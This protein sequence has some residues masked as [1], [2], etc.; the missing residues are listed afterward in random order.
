MDGYIICLLCL[1]LHWF[2]DT[3]PFV[4]TCVMQYGLLYGCSYLLA[5]LFLSMT[6]SS[7]WYLFWILNMIVFFWI[8][9]CLCALIAV[10]SVKCWTL[11]T[12]SLPAPKTNWP[13]ILITSKLITT[14]STHQSHLLS[15][16]LTCLFDYLYEYEACHK[17]KD[18]SKD[19]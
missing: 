13:G 19:L 7:T 10:Q 5:L 14:F 3:V 6:K 4:L 11:N 2:W 8:I 15:F 9:C 12:I 1:W 18:E 16:C 17:Q